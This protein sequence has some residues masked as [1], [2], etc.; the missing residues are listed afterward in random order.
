MRRLLMAVAT[1]AA[2]FGNSLPALAAGPPHGPLYLALGDSQAFGFEAHPDEKLGYAAVLSRWL[3]GSDCRDGLPGGCPN[4]E[5]INLA[6][7]GA[8]SASLIAEQLQPAV[9]IISERNNDEDP[10]N[11]VVLITITIGGNDITNPV[12]S[13]CSQGPTPACAEAIQTAFTTYAGNLIQIL[14]TLRAAA[15]DETQII[16][17]TYDN[18][19]AA[20]FRAPIAGLGDLVLEG[21]PGL[22][23]GFNDIIRSVAAA[24]DI[25]V[26]DI[27]GQLSVD[28]W[29]GGNDCTHPDTSGYHKMA[30]IFRSVV[31]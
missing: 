30:E 27:F 3:H 8:T 29:I 10:G 9:T 12:F 4:L 5:F 31:E 6:V 21:G 25:D 13:N 16:I 18:P 2:L 26:A 15:G 1:S 7:P 24:F 20:C 11:D 17:S 14:G 28:D 23:V 19:L 22:P